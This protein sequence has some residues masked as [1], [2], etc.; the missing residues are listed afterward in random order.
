MLDS[1][2]LFESTL[3]QL[4]EKLPGFKDFRYKQLHHWFHDKGVTDPKLMTNLP[5]D[6]LEAME[7]V[8]IAPEV[9]VDRVLV[10]EDGTKKLLFK[11]GD[12]YAEGVLLNYRYGTSMCMST[13]IGCAM[14]CVFCASTKGGF[15]RNITRFEM[16][17][18]LQLANEYSNSK[19]NHI[20]FMGSGEPLMNLDE[21]LGFLHY[22]KDNESFGMSLRNITLS[23]CGI[24]EKIRELSK[25]GFPIT[26]AL[27]LHSPF[28]MSRREIMPIARK[29]SISEVLKA[30]DEYIQSGNRRVTIEMALIQGKNDSEENARELSRLIK[31]KLY[32]VNLIPINP[33]EE[34]NFSVPSTDA[35]SNF[36]KILEGNQIHVTIRRELGSDIA[37]SCGQLRNR[38]LKEQNKD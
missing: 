5:K 30:T 6:L 18:M 1:S 24:P 28:D 34:V 22:L 35:I 21:V 23:T 4:K 26:L 37:A 8:S 20:V 38:A 13:Q 27:S 12:D 10:S 25:S 14:G 29:Y 17:R 31:E 36:R 16:E 3:E 2:S 15:I 33:V 7:K 19:I 9:T 11:L 32:H